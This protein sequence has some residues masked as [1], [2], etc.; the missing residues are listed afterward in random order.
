MKT[1][2]EIRCS[3]TALG[4]G[5]VLFDMD[6]P[7]EAVEET[8]TIFAEVPQLTDIFTNPTIPMSKKMDVI[9]R[10]FPK[11]MRNF[12]KN[13]CAYRRMGLIEEIFAAYD[14]YKDA[15]AGTI[16][17]VLTCVTPPD[18]EQAKGIE[19]F[20]CKKYGSK[21]ADIDIRKDDALLGGFV[22]RVGSDEYDWS[23]KGRLDRMAQSMGRQQTLSGGE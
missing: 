15:Q 20:L 16:H 17:A 1:D 3:S 4:Y 7:A 18:G 22:L 19:A 2:K 23:M 10:I 12:L 9:D 11:E 13:T 8:R 14:R 6:I 21:R 5:R